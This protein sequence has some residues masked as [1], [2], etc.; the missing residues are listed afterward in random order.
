[1][2]Y[3]TAKL[4]VILVNINPA[5]R[6]SE[7]EYVLAQSGCRMLFAAQEVKGS[8]F[9]SMVDQVQPNLDQLERAVFFDTDEWLE[10]AARG[11]P[12]DAVRAAGEALDFDDPINIQFTSGTTGFAKGATLTHHNILN[13]GYFIGEALRLHR[14]RPGLHPG[15][16]LSLL[17]HG[18]GQPRLHHARRVRWC[19][20]AEAFDPQATLEA[21]EAGALHRAVRRADDVHRRARPSASSPSSTWARCAPGSWPARRARSR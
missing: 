13:N 2:Q 7:L 12:A 5:Y 20:P 19:I 16:A 3:A 15:A 8:D 4:G 14:A 1:M 10:I 17:R 11:A 9:V 21:V 6:T 18:A